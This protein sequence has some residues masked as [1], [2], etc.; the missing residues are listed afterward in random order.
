MKRTSPSTQT[1]SSLLSFFRKF[2][3]LRSE[4]KAWKNLVF[5]SPLFN[6]LACERCLQDKSSFVSQDLLTC[7]LITCDGALTAFFQLFFCSFNSLLEVS[8]YVPAPIMEL[9]SHT[10]RSTSDS[11]VCPTYIATNQA[12]FTTV[13]QSTELQ[14]F[15][16]EGHPISC[17]SYSRHS[18]Q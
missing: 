7:N 1:P 5:R 10:T 13:Q 16:S 17:I 9:S 11:F 12:L 2:R 4:A 18:S 14:I 8:K 3:F 15:C 6:Q